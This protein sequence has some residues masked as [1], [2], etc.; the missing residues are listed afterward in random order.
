MAEAHD[1]TS[2]RHRIDH[3][4]RPSCSRS[5]HRGRTRRR[6]PRPNRRTR[7]RTRTPR[8]AGARCDRRRPGRQPP[9]YAASPTT[10][11]ATARFDAVIHNAGIYVDRTRLPTDEG[12]P[13]VLAVNVLAPYTLTALIERPARLIYLTS[14][15]HH[16]GHPSLDDLDWLQPTLERH[17]GLQRQQT[18][19][20]HLRRNARP[21][22]DRHPRQRGRPRLGPHQDGWVSRNRRPRARPHHPGLARRQRP[23]RSQRHRPGSGTTSRRRH[24][25]QPYTTPSSRTRSS[26]HSNGSP[27]S[28]SRDLTS[29]HEGPDHDGAAR[30]SC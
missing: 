12:H 18:P 10:P 14:G 6:G 1:T 9:T 26:T 8:D 2:L 25:R 15:M 19:A 22:L 29:W 5:N 20:H 23:T 28:R 24:R 17:P 7:H 3:R 13:R 21:P 27:G 4:P 16:G 30:A 11:T